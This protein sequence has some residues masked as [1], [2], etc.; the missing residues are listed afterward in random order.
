MSPGWEVLGGQQLFLVA[1][2]S[3]LPK[4]HCCWTARAP[5][6]Q[7]RSGS[8]CYGGSIVRGPRARDTNWQH[9]PLASGWL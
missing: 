6:L 2:I 8:S 3:S 5:L 1:D 9:S 7:D 4:A